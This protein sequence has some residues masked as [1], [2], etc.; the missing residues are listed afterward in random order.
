MSTQDMSAI[1]AL[2]RPNSV[3]VIGAAREPHKIGH[4]VVKNLLEGGFP[5]DKI[6]PVNPYATQ[7]LGLKCYPSVKDIPG[8][9]DLAVIVVPASVVPKVLEECAEKGVK[10]VAIISAGFKEVGNI[11]AER[12]LVEIARKGG[13][14]ILGPNI[15]GVCD[16]VKRVNA[17]FCQ[18]LP[19]PGEIAFITQSGA[20]AIALV[21][22]TRLKR[23]GLSDLVSI[24]NKADIN[25]TDLMEFFGE[26]PHTKVITM[27]IEGVDDGRR[28]MEVASKVVPKKP[29]IVLKAGKVERAVSAIRSHT[30]SLAG[31]DAAYEAAFKQVGVIR[32]PT[33]P[34][35]FD[36]AIAFAK[37][38]LPKG[39]NV[40]IVTN[41]GGAGVMATDAAAQHGIKLMDL[42]EDLAKKLRYYMPPFGSVLNPVDLTGMAGKEWY[43]GAIKELL[44]DDRVH[45]IVVLYCHTAVTKP[46]EIGDAILEAIRETGVRK[47]IVASFIGGIECLEECERLIENGVPCYESPEKAMAALGALYRYKRFLDKVGKK[48]IPEFRVNKVI[49]E[50]IINKALSEERTVLTPSEAAEVAAAYGIPVLEKPL[51]KSEDEAVAIA[52]K[53]GYPVVLEVESPQVVHKTDVG[54]I[55]LDLKGPEEVRQ[56]YRQIIENV[57]K[58]V[59]S[60]E[61]RGVIVRKMMPRG[62]EVILGATRD[63]VFGPL[64][65][66]GSGGILVELIRD[67]AFRVA[68]ISVEDAREMIEETKAYKLLKGFRGEPEADIDAVIDALVRLSKLMM[69]FEEIA[70]VDI[71]PFFVYEKGKGGL[72][73]DVKIILRPRSKPGE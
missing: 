15:V 50:T 22:W 34:D 3:A 33:F 25:E 61:I 9:V 32:A 42:P 28:F 38:P 40:V 56:A 71:N 49:V 10:A 23:I 11:E 57:K 41:G 14:R 5:P 31:S 65:M 35:L 4:Q 58:H 37:A 12:R 20:L 63:P 64:I 30:G 16:T 47:T 7:I 62:K 18:A 67:V 70:E 39:E 43:K 6:Y 73:I 69:D 46:R 1:Y 53:L 60:A 72:A 29:V 27:Y 19:M 26:D 59:P 44:R 36:W 55:I 52:D 68:P 2:L 66:F 17:S 8:D 51:A 45:A 13:F 54:A 48:T 24:G 21:G